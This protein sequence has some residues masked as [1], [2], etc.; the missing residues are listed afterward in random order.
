MA[1]STVRGAPFTR[2]PSRSEASFS[3]SIAGSYSA[4]TTTGGTARRD[5]QHVGMAARMVAEGLGVLGADF[6]ARHHA[7]QHV[8]QCVVRVRF[9][10]SRHST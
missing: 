5:D 10:L 3:T 7:P 4:S 8:A 6:T 2:S 1:A 9:C